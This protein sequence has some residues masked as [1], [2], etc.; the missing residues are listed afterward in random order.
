MQ[1]YVWLRIVVV[2]SIVLAFIAAFTG[3]RAPDRGSP[4]LSGRHSRAW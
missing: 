4:R 1:R 3:L 2:A